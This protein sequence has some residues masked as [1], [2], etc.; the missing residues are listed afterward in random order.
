MPHGEKY[1][2]LARDANYCAGRWHTDVESSRPFGITKTG[3]ANKH[4]LSSLWSGVDGLGISGPHGLW[5][6]RP[7]AWSF[8]DRASETAVGWWHIV[9][10]PAEKGE[11]CTLAGCCWLDHTYS[12]ENSPQESQ[13]H[14]ASSWTS[15]Y[16]WT[17][18]SLH[19]ETKN[20]FWPEGMR[21]FTPYRCAEIDC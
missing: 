12:G 20:I 21:R 6:R 8:P 1:R 16:G 3:W 17:G 9:M 14:H 5:T 19:F 18:L 11:G 10:K 2:F 13:H 4:Q 7:E 15:P